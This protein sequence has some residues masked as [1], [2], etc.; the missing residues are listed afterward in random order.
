M[1]KL[2][3]TLNEAKTSLRNARKERFDFLGYSFGPHCYKANGQWYSER[4]SVQEERAT[5]S[6]PKSV[7]CWCPATTIR[8]PKCATTLNSVA[9][10]LVELL[11]PW[12]APGGIP[13]CRSLRLRARARLPCAVGIKWQGAEPG[14]SPVRPSMENAGFCALNACRSM[15]RRVPRGEASRRAGCRRSARPVR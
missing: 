6:R 5:A 15:P 10:R 14:G 9:A 2:G 4:Q 8:G 13:S 7:T 12:D 11:Q 3:L 1:T